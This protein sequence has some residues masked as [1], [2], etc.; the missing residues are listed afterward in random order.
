M[1]DTFVDTSYTANIQA[2]RLLN[3]AFLE[4]DICEGF[5]DYLAIVDRFYAD[6]IEA[7][8]EG[9]EGPVI[10]RGAVR[11]LVAGFFGPIHVFAEVAGL[12]TALHG[13]PIQGD[14][15]DET[16]SLWTFELTGVTGRRCVLKW[17]SCRRWRDG[18]V[19]YERCSEIEQIGGPL[20]ADD[21]D[22]RPYASR[23]EDYVAKRKDRLRC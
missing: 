4:A 6:E 7:T 18:L 19:M 10:G 12:T 5:E 8:I 17:R 21:L 22:M 23:G 2:E 16:H 3:A 1:A 13:E 11:S 15:R 20:T 14:T 9:S